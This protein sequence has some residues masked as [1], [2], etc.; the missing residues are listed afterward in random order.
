MCGVYPKD[1]KRARD[2]LLMLGF[3]ERMDKLVM[4]K[5][6]RLYGHVLKKEDD[7]VL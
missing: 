2:L 7:N 1:R 4:A 3:N 5:C 6:V